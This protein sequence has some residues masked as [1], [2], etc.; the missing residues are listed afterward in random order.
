M[1]VLLKRRAVVQA[2]VEAAYNVPNTIG[3]ND[4]IL[5]SD[6]VYT[7]D[8]TILERDFTRDSLSNQA[9]VV[10]RMQAKMEFTT[11][12]RSNGLSNLGDAS[13]APIITRLFRAC[14]YAL[15]ALLVSTASPV[16]AGGSF[17]NDVAWVTGGTLANTDMIPYF[18]TVDTA[19]P[20]GAAKVTV[21][22]DV[23]GEG[24]ASQIVTSGSPLNLGTRGLTIT[25]TFTGNLEAGQN[26]TVWLRPPGLQLK[27]ISTNVESLTMVMYKDGV[28]HLMPGCF[29]TFEITANSAQ[30]ATVKW[31]FWGTYRQPEDALMPSPIYEKT[32][33]AMIELARL[34]VDA[35]YAIVDKFTFTQGNDVQIRP[36]VSSEQG[37]IG[38]RIVGR[39]TEGGID[40]EA[41]LVAN[42]DFWGAMRSA[43]RMSFQM[44][45]GTKVGNTVW[46][47]APSVQYT[48]LTYGD[49][50]GILTYDAGLKFSGYQSD[51][52][53]NFF[54]C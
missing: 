11:E 13:K 38:T 21:T 34:R 4:G 25:P 35:F 7:A 15:T 37:Y 26:W 18:L 42:Y 1:T 41:D 8:P 17:G 24:S 3:V 49:R 29:G 28:K 40:P 45:V 9:H 39:T 44:R 36:D 16:F 30:Y 52:E 33:P 43:D 31:S 48:K 53:I 27:P 47:T 14:G 46:I 50:N 51:D 19:G 32:L 22:S 10:G 54:F 23:P 20:S 5:C 12:L 6:P 2:V